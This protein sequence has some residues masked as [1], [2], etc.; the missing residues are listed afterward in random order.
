MRLQTK[1][2]LIFLALS[3]LPLFLM[4]GVAYLTAE[5][6]IKK[7]LGSSFQKIAHEA[8]DKVDRNIY[9]I[10]RNIDTWSKLDLMQEVIT[11][12]LDGNITS[13]LIGLNKEY[14]YFSSIV[15]F[16]RAGKAVAS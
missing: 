3:L 8:S 11:G 10:Y 12:D 9:E 6:A 14:G 7:S 15:A 5:D 16:N 4:G 13:F 1:T 2:A